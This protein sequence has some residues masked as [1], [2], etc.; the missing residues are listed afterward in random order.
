MPG[1]GAE[2]RDALDGNPFADQTA[3]RARQR[4]IRAGLVRQELDAIEALARV[5]EFISDRASGGIQREDVG[6]LARVAFPNVLEIRR[7]GK[8]LMAQRPL[9][10]SPC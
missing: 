9:K 8:D 5:E 3:Q 6:R 1:M 4:R 10:G 7:T 2:R